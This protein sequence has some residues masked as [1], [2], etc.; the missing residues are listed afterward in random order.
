MGTQAA[1]ALNAKAVF[2]ASLEWSIVIQWFDTTGM[3]ELSSN[4]VAKLSLHYPS[5]VGHHSGF[6]VEIFNKKS[7][8]IDTKFFR[9]DDFLDRSARTDDR[10]D[11]PLGTNTCFQVIDH[12]GWRWYIAQPRTTKPFCEAVEKYIDQWR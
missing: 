5:T 8:R 12:C 4:R 7:G 3:H 11:Y 10:K 1:P 9:F 2:C 6:R